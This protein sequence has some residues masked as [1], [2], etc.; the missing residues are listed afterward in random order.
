MEYLTTI[1][2][3]SEHTRG[4]QPSPEQVAA[5]L[6][7]VMLRAGEQVVSV[8]KPDGGFASGHF[9]ITEVSAGVSA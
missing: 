2:V 6:A 1:R 3:R 7:T 8:D 4:P 5:A 9:R